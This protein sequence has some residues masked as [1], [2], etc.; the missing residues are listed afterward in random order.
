MHNLPDPDRQPEFYDSVPAKR[1]FAWVV[2]TVL[3]GLLCILILPF[4]AFAALF[5][6]PLLFAVISFVYRVATLAGGSATWGMRLAAIE[7]RTDRGERFD[8]GTA[9]MHTLGYMVSFAIPILQVI[10]VI[11]MLNTARG[12]GLTDTVLGSA[13]LNRRSVR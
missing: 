10:S 1:L 7:F 4:T 3:I 6:L 9:L 5:F 13:A 8:T 12:Q 2:D 11:M